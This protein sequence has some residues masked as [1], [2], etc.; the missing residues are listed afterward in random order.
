[1]DKGKSAGRNFRGCG[2]GSQSG[3]TAM[4][5]IAAWLGLATVLRSN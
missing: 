4:T 2:V 1:M 5:V 3:E